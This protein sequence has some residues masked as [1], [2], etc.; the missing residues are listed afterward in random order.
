MGDDVGVPLAQIKDGTSS[1]VLLVETKQTVPW[2]KPED[3]LFNDYADAKLALPFDGLDLNCLMVDGTVLS[4]KQ[5]IDWKRLGNL[6]TRDGGEPSLE[7][8]NPY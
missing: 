6:V 3:L 1:T 4:L 5:P 2:T 8:K 7:G